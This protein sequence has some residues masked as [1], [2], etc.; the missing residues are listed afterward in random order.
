MST[1]PSTTR[2]RLP[3]TLRCTGERR[4]DRVRASVS[5]LPEL[6]SRASTLILLENIWRDEQLLALH[7]ASCWGCHRTV[8]VLLEFG[9]AKDVLNH[10]GKTPRQMLCLGVGSWTA[11]QEAIAGM[12]KAA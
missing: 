3:V 12:F 9:A 7:R 6:L 8:K 5:Q 10:S 2:S 1:P 4:C 11:Y